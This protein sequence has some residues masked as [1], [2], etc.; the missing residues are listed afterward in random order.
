MIGPH[1]NSRYTK[2]VHDQPET[3]TKN[4]YKEI[5]TITEKYE[6]LIKENREARSI[7]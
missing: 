4:S 1:Q 2:I 7:M 3:D 5:D 6:N